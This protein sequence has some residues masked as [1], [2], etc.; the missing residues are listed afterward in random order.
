[1]ITL[2]IDFKQPAANKIEDESTYVH[3]EYLLRDIFLSNSFVSKLRLKH[4]E[5]KLYRALFDFFT[6][7]I[8]PLILHHCVN[9]VH[10]I[11]I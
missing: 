3:C 6:I 1:M 4:S 7:W 9:G 2:E 10:L 11:L 8:Y 5:K